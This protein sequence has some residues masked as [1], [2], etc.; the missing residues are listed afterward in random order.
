MGDFTTSDGRTVRLGRAM[1]DPAR[2]RVSLWLHDFVDLAAVVVPSKVD[3]YT[4]AASCI[5][6]VLGNEDESDC[7]CASLFHQLYCAAAG[8]GRSLPLPTAAEALALYHA[9]GGPGDS[10]LVIQTLLD[11]IRRN[12]FTAGGQPHT[13]LGYASVD[14]TDLKL[15]KI[16][17]AVNGS[18]KIGINLPAAWQDEDTW[19]VTHSKI[20]GG[21]DVP[22][23]GFDDSRGGGRGA[24]KVASWGGLYD[25]T[26]DAVECG[27]YVEESWV[28]L[29]P[30]LVGDDGRAPVG[31]DLATLK[32]YM[33][34]TARGE[35][36]PTPPTPPPWLDLMG[37]GL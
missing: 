3:Y 20:R 11:F 21:H 17:V 19:D 6:L 25:L 7:T 34:I 23:V 33:R 31:V 2:M 32:A 29:F 18:V 27:K 30:E 28:E 10:G 24:F 37:G 22:I 13:I 16:A 14:F 15:L 1:P 8:A 9:V 36:P 4:A 35:K 5:A 12:G 26:Y